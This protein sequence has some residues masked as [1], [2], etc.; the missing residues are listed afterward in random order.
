M[1]S[2]FCPSC[3]YK[4]QYEL[5]KPEKCKSC[6][7]TMENPV[8]KVSPKKSCSSDSSASFSFEFVSDNRSRS[9]DY[10]DPDLPSF[11]ISGGSLPIQTLGDIKTQVDLNP[12]LKNQ[13][14]NRKKEKSVSKE[15]I[16][17]EFRKEAGGKA[18]S[19]EISLD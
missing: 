9:S 1:K 3:G 5:E 16:L 8:A 15:N 6:G 12:D 18:A 19:Q 13:K 11:K 17:K 7:K 2:Y 14:I 4:N 10:N